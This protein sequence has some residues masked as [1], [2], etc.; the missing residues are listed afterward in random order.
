MNIEEKLRYFNLKETYKEDDLNKAYQR[1]LEELNANYEILKS[2][3]KKEDTL[4]YQAQI[5]ACIAKVDKIVLNIILSEKIDEEMA[6]IL[7]TL[8][9]K[10]QEKLKSHELDPDLIAYF[11]NLKYD[12]SKDDLKLLYEVS[13]GLIPTSEE[14]STRNKR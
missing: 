10:I 6:R 2:R 11:T 5:N 7:L 9:L 3:L 1:K 13:T 12:G 8:L 14:S 4:E